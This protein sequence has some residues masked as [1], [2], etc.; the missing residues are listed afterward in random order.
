M[1]DSYHARPTGLAPRDK[2]ERGN[3]PHRSAPP[4]QDKLPPNAALVVGVQ[5]ERRSQDD[6]AVSAAD[7]DADCR[8][9]MNSS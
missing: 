6:A 3:Q 7:D 9:S 1:F 5:G 8:A 4:P 2:W